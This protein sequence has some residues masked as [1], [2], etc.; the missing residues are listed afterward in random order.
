MQSPPRNPAAVDP[1]RPDPDDLAR[2]ARAV[3]MASFVGT[4]APPWL[5]DELAAGLGAV[6]LFSPNI[7]DDEQLTGLIA[8]LRAANPGVVIAVDEEGGDVTRLDRASGSDLPGAATLGAVDDI[9]ATA[10]AYRTIGRRLRRIGIDLDLAPVADVNSTAEN[11]VIGVR[12]FG[13][14]PA[15]VARHVRA[16]VDGLQSVGVGAC[17]KHFPGH[18]ATV[19]DSHLGLPVV[20]APPELLEQRELVPFRDSAAAAVMSAHLVVPAFGTQPATTNA[21]VLHL[22]R[23]DLG[24]QGAILSDALD[25]A[26]VHGPDTAAADVTPTHIAAAAVRALAAGCDV[27]CLGARQGPDVPAAVTAALIATVE[28]GALDHRRLA[29]AATRARALR[30][31]ADVDA[32]GDPADDE[33]LAAGVAARA[34]R[35]RGDLPS[36]LAGAL[37]VECRA[38]ASM[39]NF[40]VA[41]GLGTAVAALDPAATTLTVDL[42]TPPADAIAAAAGRPLVVAVRGASVHRWQRGLLAAMSVERP[43]LVAVELGWPDDPHLGACLPGAATVTSFGASRASTA[44]VAQLLAGH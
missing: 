42:D 5:L 36:D 40:D 27:L 4:E 43:D 17:L 18:G 33:Q 25:M 22:L 21:A 24:F 12:S 28:T 10:A 19:G 38:E 13:D 32:P 29:E 23:D 39:A 31:P 2:L 3:Q 20:D 6:C 8:E 7:V 26:G 35:V 1:G 34:L 14:D 30:A 44:A 15:L 9:A 16:A 37:V 11:P 41:W